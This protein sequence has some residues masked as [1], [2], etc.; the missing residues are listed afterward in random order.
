MEKRLL[1]LL[2][3]FLLL[4]PF[5]NAFNAQE[6]KT[7]DI[8]LAVVSSSLGFNVDTDKIYF[9]DVLRGASSIKKIIIS[10]DNFE[11]SLVIIKVLGELEAWVSI[12]ENDFILKKGEYKLVELRATVPIDAA[13]GAYESKLLTTY[14]EINSTNKEELLEAINTTKKETIEEKERKVEEIVRFN[15]D[16]EK[17][18]VETCG[19]SE[20]LDT[21]CLETCTDAKD[22]D[23]EKKFLNEEYYRALKD[24]YEY[25]D[26]ITLE[27]CTNNCGLGSLNCIPSDCI[28]KCY[29]EVETLDLKE[30]F[31]TV[32]ALVDFE[33]PSVSV[34]K[35]TSNIIDI[36]EGEIIFEISNEDAY[37]SLEGYWDC[38]IPEG[39][40]ASS[41]GVSVTEKYESEK[42]VLN[43]STTRNAVL[44]LHSEDEGNKYVNC[45]VNYV[46]FKEGRGYLT[47]EGRYSPGK[48]YQQLTVRKGVPFV[49]LSAI[50]KFA[51]NKYFLIIVGILWLLVFFLLYKVYK[52]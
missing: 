39:V 22:I 16:V 3:L 21:I 49:K 20:C 12:S 35:V 28:K 26:V 47:K 40:T 29:L 24:Y 6:V 51:V 23:F 4:I 15:I 32:E 34:K 14:Y 48:E 11:E 44:T 46:L 45:N 42:F 1:L 5:S 33:T 2:S 38:E 43:P 36:K 31:K 18:C 50:K 9:G 52:K 41:E 19:S 13:L 10:N 8:Q 37:H 25:R 30:L 7:L 27:N 17:E